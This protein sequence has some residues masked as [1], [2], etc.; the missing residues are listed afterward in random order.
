MWESL[1]Y[2]RS[3]FFDDAQQS[4]PRSMIQM[5]LACILRLSSLT[6]VDISVPKLQWAKAGLL[7]TASPLVAHPTLVE[8]LYFEFLPGYAIC[9]GRMMD[10]V[11]NI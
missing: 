4:A 6:G 3:G 7:A 11:Q 8:Q 1:P 2:C 10:T 5:V 9:L